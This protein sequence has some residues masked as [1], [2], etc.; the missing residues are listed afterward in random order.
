MVDAVAGDPV[1]AGTLAIA[2]L[3]VLGAA[4]IGVARGRGIR[5]AL[6]TGL[7]LS[8]VLIGVVTLGSVV[9]GQFVGEPGLNL[10]PF[11]EI[12]R[13]LNNRGSSSWTNVV[14]NVA[15]FV[16]F[17]FAIACLARGGLW[18]RW[19]LATVS[20][21]VFSS[22]IEVTQYALGRVADIDDIMLNTAGAFAGGLV[23]ALTAVMVILAQREP[24]AAAQRTASDAPA[25]PRP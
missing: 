6:W 24:A 25:A 14:G 1:V 3:A 23:G 2:M 17:G 15:L 21:L 9:T 20:G 8:V 7:A 19:L 11:Q 10:V 16:P 18:V 4:V 12:Q 13:G 22:A 5:P